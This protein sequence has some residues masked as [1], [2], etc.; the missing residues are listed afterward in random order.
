MREG[1]TSYTNPAL[2]EVPPIRTYECGHCN[3]KRPGNATHCY[4]CGVCVEN[5]RPK[6]S[7]HPFFAKLARC[8]LHNFPHVHY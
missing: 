3:I 6:L 2:P 7:S 4:D 5:V 1:P 8:E